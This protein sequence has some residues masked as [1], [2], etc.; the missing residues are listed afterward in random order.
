VRLIWRYGHI[1]GSWNLKWGRNS[2]GHTG[3]SAEVSIITD[4]EH[5]KI[6]YLSITVLYVTVFHSY[7]NGLELQATAKFKWVQATVKFKLVGTPSHT[8]ATVTE[9]QIG[10]NSNPLLSSNGLEL[11]AT[12]KLKLVGTPSHCEIQMGW[13]SK[14]LQRSN[15]LELQAATTQSKWL[16]TPSYS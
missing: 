2:D 8:A 11:Q 7:S 9:I 15:G 16:G 1:M 3:T 6:T 13:N 12:V 5:Y 4:T 14:P 10:W